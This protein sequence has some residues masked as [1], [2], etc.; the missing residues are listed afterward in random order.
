MTEPSCPLCVY[1]S[2]QN[3]RLMNENLSLRIKVAEGTASESCRRDLE[4]VNR[5]LAEANAELARCRKKAE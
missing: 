5:R 1:L 4:L 2:K 3:E